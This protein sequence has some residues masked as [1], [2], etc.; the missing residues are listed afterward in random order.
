MAHFL[1]EGNGVT[2]H[3]AAKQKITR[4]LWEG[5]ALFKPSERPGRTATDDVAGHRRRGLLGEAEGVNLAG[6]LVK[7]GVEFS[8]VGCVGVVLRTRRGAIDQQLLGSRRDSET[9]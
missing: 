4:I 8:F 6:E 7:G 9:E 2:R 5:C 3:P 1:D